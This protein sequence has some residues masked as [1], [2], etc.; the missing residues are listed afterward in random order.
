MARE[1]VF[2]NAAA[3]YESWFET[4]LGSYL[5]RQELGAAEAV[6]PAASEGGDV[7]EVGAGTGHVVRFLAERGYRL[8][9]VEPSEAMRLVGGEST[10][11]LDVS[12]VD[13]VGEALPFEDGQFDGAVYFATIEFVDDPARALAEALRVVRPGGWLA[14]GYLHALSPWAALYRYL[15]EQGNEPWTAARFFVR[16]GLTG[17]VGSEPVASAQAGWLAPMAEEPFEAADEAGKRAGNMPAFEVLL[18]RKTG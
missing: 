9:A 3:D 10:K 15:A 4:P 16:D 8:T 6:L 17:L 1:D 2:A 18:W 12:W 7:V 11:G 14:V 5:D 13:A